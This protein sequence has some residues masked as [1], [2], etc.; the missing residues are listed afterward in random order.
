[1]IAVSRKRCLLV[2]SFLWVGKCPGAARSPGNWYCYSNLQARPQNYKHQAHGC[3]VH[4]IDSWSADQKGHIRFLGRA[5]LCPIPRRFVSCLGM[6]Q[7]SMERKCC[8][9]IRAGGREFCSQLLDGVCSRRSRCQHSWV[10][11]PSLSLR[12]CVTWSM[13]RS[14]LSL[15]FPICRMAIAISTSQGYYEV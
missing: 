10:L 8:L 4:L 14:P 15:S 2:P 1:M 9:V 7:E 3:V 5:P 13:S 11:F 6:K 12:C